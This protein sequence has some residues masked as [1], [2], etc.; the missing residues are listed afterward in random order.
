M[1]SAADAVS[2]DGR[3]R[4]SGAHGSEDEGDGEAGEELG[5]QGGG[6]WVVDVLTG[7]FAPKEG[8]PE[9]EFRMTNCSGLAVS[10]IGF[11]SFIGGLVRLLVAGEFNAG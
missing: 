6:G 1:S 3:Q 4:W 5:C 9:N 2:E 7:G 10:V 11:G 8:D